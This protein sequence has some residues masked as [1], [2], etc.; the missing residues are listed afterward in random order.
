MSN[1]VRIQVHWEDPDGAKF[2]AAQKAK[3][4]KAGEAAGAEFAGAT[5]RKAKQAGDDA[6]EEFSGSFSG[7][8]TKK[9]IAAAQKA[10]AEAAKSFSGNFSGNLDAELAKAAK[11]VETELAKAKAPAAKAGEEVGKAAGD[12]VEKGMRD[13]ARK[14]GKATDDEMRR[15]AGRANKAFDG[16]VFSGLS[17]GLPAAAAVGV[18]GVAAAVAAVPALFLGVAAAG[19]ASNEKVAT[20]YTNLGQR[21]KTTTQGMS[22]DLEDEAL[23]VSGKLGASFDRLAPK[24][25]AAMSASGRYV[26]DFTDGITGLA[27]NAM[28]GLL[29][30]TRQAGPAVQ[31]LGSFMKQAG[32]GASEMLTNMSREADSAGA[33]IARLGG[34]VRNALAFTG[35][36]TANLA[37]NHRELGILDAA[38][39]QVEQTLLHLTTAGSGAVGFLHGF[40]SAGVGALSVVNGIAAGLSLIPAQVTQF[41]G[42]FLAA[43]MLMRKFGVDATASFDGLGERIR[44]AQTNGDKFK[45]AMTGLRDA[46]LSP[47]MLATAGLSIAL[48]GLGEAQ[49]KA[50]ERAQEH[51]NNVTELT[52]A[53][54][55][56]KGVISEASKETIAHALTQKNA[57]ANLEAAG[58][59]I[60]RATVAATG[61]ARVMREV[62]DQTNGWI[63]TAGQK[64][65]AQQRDIDLIKGANQLLLQQ[66][67]AYSELNPVMQAAG[68]SQQEVTAS[69]EAFS[70]VMARLGPQQ[71]NHLVQLLNGTGAIGQQARAAREAYD[72]YQLEEQGLTGLSEAQIKA[73]DSTTQH[74]EAI[75]AQVNASLGLRGAQQ[76]SKQALDDYNQSLKGGSEDEKAAALLRLEQAWQA[77]LS[78]VQKSTEAHSA[79]PTEEGRHA[80][81]MAAM[82]TRAVE[83]ANTFQGSLPASLAETIGQFTVTQARAAGLTVA[84]DGTGQAVYRLPNGKEIKIAANTGQAVEAINQV[85]RAQDALYNK[86]VT[87]TIINRVVDLRTSGGAYQPSLTGRPAYGASGGLI[88]HLPRKAF[89]M[90][91]VTGLASGGSTMVDI[92]GGGFLRGPG[93]G[94]SD[95]IRALSSAGRVDVADG[96]FVIRASQTRKWRPLLEDINAGVNGFAGGGMVQAEDGSWVPPSFYGPAPQGPHAKYTASGFA[97][98]TAQA[99]AYGIGSL[100]ADDQDQLRTYGGWTDT[101]TAGSATPR[102]GYVTPTGGRSGPAQIELVVSGGGSDLERMFAEMI[103]RYVKVNGGG[104]VQLA[105]GQR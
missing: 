72:A 65:G 56:D 97:K 35:S 90:G 31:G 28:P 85:K 78:A 36:L 83:L 71:A 27:E 1:D 102:N 68:K 79:A 40:G 49:Q 7:K 84:I 62:T 86:T 100:D 41:G 16:L 91:G 23:V 33:G 103:R 74:T 15:V 96:E 43:G 94:T 95:S 22:A 75:Y 55:K 37:A 76:S 39:T 50:A 8:L 42:S 59:S 64:A 38:A 53:I 57:A 19:L 45:T 104:N 26:D 17:L 30:V 101:I 47:A 13:G 92:T 54:R 52:E 60:G 46:A 34:T 10:G 88:K 6:A 81:A 61:N 73:R 11:V 99:K 24:V 4:K 25:D 14:G 20:S 2:Q 80:E 70:R 58:V 48:W 98:L 77:E 105:F 9:S 87:H 44:S 21:I 32:A 66:G 51:K 82:N 89:A 67:G 18:A 63:Q 12:G 3:A 29:T 69:N 5:R 93:T